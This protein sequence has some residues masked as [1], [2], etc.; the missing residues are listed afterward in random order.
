MFLYLFAKLAQI[1]HP[2]KGGFWAFYLHNSIIIRNFAVEKKKGD[3]S[4]QKGAV[5]S[6]QRGGAVYSDQSTS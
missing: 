6:D 5:Y 3:Y 2:Q 1:T 4:E